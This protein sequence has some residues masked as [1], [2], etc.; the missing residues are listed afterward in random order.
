[1]QPAA[2]NRARLPRLGV[3][4][5]NGDITAP[6]VKV[7]KNCDDAITISGVARNNRVISIST[8]KH[9]LPPSAMTSGQELVCADGRSAIRTPK[10]PNKTAPQHRQPARSRSTIADSAVTKIGQAR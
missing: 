6:K 9:R 10:K 1:M 5:P 4:Q 3:P 8:E 7:P 2:A